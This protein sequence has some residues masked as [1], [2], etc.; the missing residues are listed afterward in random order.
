MKVAYIYFLYI[1]LFVKLDYKKVQSLFSSPTLTY[2]VYMQSSCKWVNT[3]KQ[4][5]PDFIH[6]YCVSDPSPYPNPNLKPRLNPKMTLILWEL[7][8]C[9]KK[10]GKCPQCD[11][12]NKS[13]SPQHACCGDIDLSTKHVDTH[14]H[15]KSILAFS[16]LQ[17]SLLLCPAGA[18][19]NVS[20]K[21]L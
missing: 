7:A 5:Y 1:K 4:T 13:M 11:Y 19:I 3:H 12:V 20:D 10:V 9:P 18:G 14:T 17:L 8:F 2:T 21:T 16:H 6:N 15:T